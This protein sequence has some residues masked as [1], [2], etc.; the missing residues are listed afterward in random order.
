MAT[1]N[2]GNFPGRIELGTEF[3]LH[4]G[5]SETRNVIDFTEYKLV[6]YALKCKDPQQ[7]LILMALVDDYR[8]GSVAISWRRGAP[9]PVRV[10][11]EA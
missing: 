9:V 5:R 10:T 8:A 6:R 4:V 3:Q 1:R 11:K 7:K 2:T